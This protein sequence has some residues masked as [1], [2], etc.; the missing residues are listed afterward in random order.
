MQTTP[1]TPI[2]ETTGYSECLD[3]LSASGGARRPLGTYRL[4]FNA[5]F[6]F[7]DAELLL[8]YLDALGVSHCYASPVMQARAGSLHGYDIT[9]H[10]RLNEEI[11]SEEDFRRLTRELRARE[12]GIILD[13][14]P[15]HVGVGR[16]NV[17]W[18]DVLEN[19]RASQF[20]DYFDIDWEPLK[21]ELQE[22]I[23]LPVLGAQ[24][25]EELENGLL[26][27]VYSE[28]EARF[29]IEYYENRFP[30]DPQTYLLIFGE[31]RRAGAHCIGLNPDDRLPPEPM[32]GELRA[33]MTEFS[34]LPHHSTSDP[35]L[36]E[37]RRRRAPELR[38]RF[39]ELLRRCGLKDYLRHRIA[40]VNGDAKDPRSFD[41]LHRL[42]EAQ[43][44]RLAHWKVSAEEIN[45]RRFFDINDLVGLRMENPA[46]F[47]ATHQMVR[48]LLAEPAVT[49]LRID[50]PD[51]L[52]NPRPYFTRLQMLY[53]AA[54]CAGPE[55]RST[56]AE[57][58]IEADFLQVFGRHSWLNRP[59]LYLIIEKI[60]E[61]GEA[62]PA[63]WP[64]DGTVGYDFAAL[65]NGLFIDP[66]SEK[67]LT[68]LYRRFT[69]Q[70]ETSEEIVYRSKRVIMH[71]ALPSEISVLTHM[72]AEI[73]SSDRHARDFT[74]KS[75]RDA[76]R[77]IIACFP[78]Y[79]TYVDERGVVSERDRKI[80]MLATAR[81]MRRNAVTP[82]AVFQFVRDVLL[83]EKLVN[84]DARRKRLH[85]AL[86][87]QQLTGPV[88]AKGLEDT[89]FY[90]Y[91][92]FI[93]A[94]DVGGSLERF[95]TSLDEFHRANVER[96]AHWPNAM[97]TTSTHDSKRSEDVRARLNVL[98]EMPAAWSAQ[99]HRWRRANAA[100]KP[101]IGDGRRIPDAN[102]EYLLYQSI[103]GAAPLELL[104]AP[105][106]APAHFIERIQQYM[107]K[108]VH[109]AKV[110]LSWVNS[111]AEYVRALEQFIA[112]IFSAEAARRA[113]SFWKQFT[114]FLSPVC[115]FGAINSLAQTVLKLT[116]PGVP[117]V[118]QGNE[119]WDFSLV[120]PDNRRP[121]D[122]ELRQALLQDLQAQADAGELAALCGEILREWQDGRAKLWTT[123][124][125]L[126]LR[127]EREQLFRCGFYVPLDASGGK[128]AHVCAFARIDEEHGEI[129][130]TAAPR[131][132]YTL[133]GGALRPPLGDIW[134]DTQ[135]QLPR[136]AARQL[137]NV[138][139]G[140]VCEI[141][142]RGT[143]S[144]REIFA[145]FPV[146]LLVG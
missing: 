106:A 99:V 17:W 102:E 96:A 107:F 18:Q 46:V 128:H 86:K 81:A 117:D 15:N 76:V 108:A 51:G 59:P 8:G 54:H 32:L 53:C 84:A 119:I 13:L 116:S 50:H 71:S 31:R 12:M 41:C 134:G 58:G 132:S 62:L 110:N 143:I 141:S 52:L 118:Y 115:Y 121:V 38:E 70:T 3:R 124:Q 27:L 94:N 77:E 98:S 25:G 68:L 82:A 95:A 20:A 36:V 30:V 87:F 56:P 131:L 80:I 105:E 16:H 130:V 88:M 139:S 7:A 129:A 101:T 69:A 37:A 113:N 60:L 144:C 85:F 103:V 75:L 79:R 40:C 126:R 2:T 89:A 24:Y 111:N 43:A 142:E 42:L 127:R 11:G 100:S 104:L 64:V 78:V 145:D 9:D 97:L 92:R 74:L 137:V 39:R 120:D 21:P 19:G 44:Y 35:E 122:F 140:R 109:E 72:L 57:N 66:R 125:A 91:N 23:L 4:Q 146:A 135:L 63:D 5:K 114:R 61:P 48:R 14:V 45:Y 22:K 1:V 90:V 133:M 34:E 47:A 6:R 65:V 55:P 123:M 93:S 138:F 33:L 28:E 26:K 29:F 136:T 112:R 83:L 10:N 73:C 67:P 49:G